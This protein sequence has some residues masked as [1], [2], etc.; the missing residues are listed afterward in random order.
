MSVRCMVVSSEDTTAEHENSYWAP[1]IRSTLSLLMFPSRTG[2]ARFLDDPISEPALRPV[3][4]SITDDDPG[5]SPW[6]AMRG[7][8]P[9]LSTGK[10]DPLRILMAIT[11]GVSR[12]AWHADKLARYCVL[13]GINETRVDNKALRPLRPIPFRAIDE[14]VSIIG[15]DTGSDWLSLPVTPLIPNE[16]HTVD[17]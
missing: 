12:D 17:N 11:E 6:G 1:E 2:P 8:R 13:A 3:R 9:S 15:M 16:V 7:G 14:F 10:S 5:H 4:L